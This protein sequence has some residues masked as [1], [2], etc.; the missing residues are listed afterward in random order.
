[1]KTKKN[2]KQKA[3]FKFITDMWNKGKEGW[4]KGTKSVAD[5]SKGLFSSKPKTS[6]PPTTT[7]VSSSSLNQPMTSTTTM[8]S[9]APAPIGPTINNNNVSTASIG[10]N[11]TSMTP[12]TM[13]TQQ[14]YSNPSIPVTS[15]GRRRKRL[16]KYKRGGYNLTNASPVSNEKVA[17]PTYWLTGGK[18]RKSKRRKTSK[19]RKSKRKSKRRKTRY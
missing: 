19:K 7:S 11:N 15:G 17:T 8:P 13:S 3:G 6:P 5:S 4:N 1:M 9:T 2:R 14:T 16:S 18:K 12:S 10:S